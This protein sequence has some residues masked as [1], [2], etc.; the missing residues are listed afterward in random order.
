MHYSELLI[1][2]QSLCG[3]LDAPPRC[4]SYTDGTGYKA[5]SAPAIA[6]DANMPSRDS[7]LLMIHKSGMHQS[8]PVLSNSQNSSRVGIFPSGISHALPILRLLACLLL[9]TKEKSGDIGCKCSN[10]ADAMNLKQGADVHFSLAR[11]PAP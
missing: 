2:P 9:V 1:I 8:N 6:K 7:F 11:T 5:L 10:P 4:L 3:D